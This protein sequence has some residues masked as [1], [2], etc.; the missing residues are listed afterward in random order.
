MPYSDQIHRNVSLSLMKFLSGQAA[1]AGVEIL[2]M[3]EF[4]SSK[5]NKKPFLL[6]QQGTPKLSPMAIDGGFWEEEFAANAQNVTVVNTIYASMA[7]LEFGL[8]LGTD[9]VA[10]REMW[11]AVLRRIFKSAE[12]TGIPVFN[13]HL[14][15]N[16]TDQ[17]GKMTYIT[18]AALED[19][20]IP[21]H[22]EVRTWRNLL[23]FTPDYVHRFIQTPDQA[24]LT[25]V[26]LY[27]KEISEY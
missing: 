13:L 11:T 22:P 18:E 8:D 6:M 14:A 3:L 12:L 2:P 19:N 26:D 7:R 27:A 15:A 5:Y 4:D 25:G 21:E 1:L 24:P 10:D 20:W 23:R 17:V 16:N 9:T